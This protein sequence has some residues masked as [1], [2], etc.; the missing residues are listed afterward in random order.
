M[1]SDAIEELISN[2][3]SWMVRWGITIFF[4]TLLFL[5][6]IAWIIKYPDTVSAPLKITTIDAPKSIQAKIGGKLIKL[7][8][9][10]NDSVNTNDILAFIESTAS[11]EQVLKLSTDMDTISSLIQGGQVEIVSN[12]IKNNYAQLGEVQLAYQNFYSAYLQFKNYLSSGFYL[13]KKNYLYKDLNNLRQLQ[14]SIQQEKIIY[15]QDYNLA[16][17]AYK[18]KQQLANDKV[19]ALSELKEEES[20]LLAKKMPLQ[21]LTAS[22][23]NNQSLQNDKQKELLELEKQIAEQKIFFY[24]LPI[25]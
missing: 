17:Q 2:D 18:R 5:L 22:A 9:Q 14:V 11:H 15:T 6:T 1:R 12:H 21:Q 7:F 16:E 20:K 25:L 4:F 13:A 8:V 19:I 3:P 10:P 23:I 24:K